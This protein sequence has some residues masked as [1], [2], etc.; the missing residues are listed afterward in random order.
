MTVPDEYKE[1][2]ASEWPMFRSFLGVSQQ[3]V[4][5]ALR[6][7][8]V[9]IILAARDQGISEGSNAGMALHFGCFRFSGLP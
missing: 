3:S 7:A 2:E 8:D 1:D 6:R 5:K 9:G 4:G